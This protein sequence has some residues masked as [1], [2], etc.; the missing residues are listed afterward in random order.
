MLAVSRRTFI[1]QSGKG[2]TSTALKITSLQSI[3]ARSF[4]RR[5]VL[6]HATTLYHIAQRWKNREIEFRHERTRKLDPYHDDLQR[7]WKS[8]LENLTEIYILVV[9]MATHIEK[10]QPRISRCLF[11]LWHDYILQVQL[12]H[13]SMRQ[14]R[15]IH[16]EAVLCDSRLHSSSF[17]ARQSG[18]IPF[19]D[20]IIDSS[21]KI[22]MSEKHHAEEE[23]SLLREAIQAQY[24]EEHPYSESKPVKHQYSPRPVRNLYKVTSRFAD[25]RSR[26]TR[27]SIRE[28]VFLREIQYIFDPAKRVRDLSMD[29]SRK[30]DDLACTLD[31]AKALNL[32]GYRWTN[33]DRWRY[34]LHAKLKE[35]NS[36]LMS[37]SIKLEQATKQLET[38]VLERLDRYLEIVENDPSQLPLIKAHLLSA[39]K[40]VFQDPK[41]KGNVLR[42]ILDAESMLKEWKSVIYPMLH[43]LAQFEDTSIP[44]HHRKP[45]RF[46]LFNSE[47]VRPMNEGDDRSNPQNGIA[48]HS[49]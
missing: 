2:R 20:E 31:S 49:S 45:L 13:I 38:L 14:Y 21:V 17:Q 46:F 41:F 10:K 3:C 9:E 47:Y 7:H 8:H 11:W 44:A 26:A 24:P 30:I 23:T 27:Q 35:Q 22:S 12:N 18:V 36:G 40:P 33:K 48:T 25:A 34:G 42:H 19:L 32:V 16:A 4:S 29:T 15:E 5:L 43:F 28:D 6:P 39:N 1:S 37:A